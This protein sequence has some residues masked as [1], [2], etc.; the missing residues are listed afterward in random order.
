MTNMLRAPALVAVAFIITSLPALADP[1]QSSQIRVV[2]G[3]TI[4]ARGAIYRMVGYDAP[5]LRRGGAR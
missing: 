4:E 1:I 3:D 5:E 2:D